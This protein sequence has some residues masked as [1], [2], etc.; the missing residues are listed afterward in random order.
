[1]GDIGISAPDIPQEQECV[2]YEFTCSPGCTKQLTNEVYAF[3]SF[4]HMHQAG[5]SIWTSHWRG[6]QNLGYTNRIEYWDFGFQH[7]SRVN[8]TIKP[9]DRYENQEYSLIQYLDC[10]HNVF[11]ILLHDLH[12][13]NL[14]TVLF[15]KCALILFSIGKLVHNAN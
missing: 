10:T 15:K 6:D 4:L 8:F 13:L 11:M 2:Q 5:R 1:M 3:A 12:Q 14:D 7:Q 9:G